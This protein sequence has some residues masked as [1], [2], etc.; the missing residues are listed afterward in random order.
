MKTALLTLNKLQIFAEFVEKVRIL[1]FILFRNV[2][3]IYFKDTINPLTL[4]I[5]TNVIRC[6]KTTILSRLFI[7]LKFT[8]FSPIVYQSLHFV[9]LKKQIG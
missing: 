5:F 8:R 7:Y 3:M 6:S 4:F 1:V 9:Q 2:I